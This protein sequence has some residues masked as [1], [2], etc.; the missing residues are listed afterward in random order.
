MKDEFKKGE[1]IVFKDGEHEDDDVSC[2]AL[3]IKDFNFEFEQ[4]AFV[5]SNAFTFTSFGIPPEYYIDLLKSNKTKGHPEFH[6]HLQSKGIVNILEH[7]EIHREYD[8]LQVKAEK[9]ELWLT[10]NK[11]KLND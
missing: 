2:I 7:E 11:D 9:A 5:K 3:V 1:L 10:Y 4:E 6:L 8:V